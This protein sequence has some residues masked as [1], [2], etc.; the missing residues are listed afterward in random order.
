MPREH[1]I[2]NGVVVAIIVFFITAF[3]TTTLQDNA[4]VGYKIGAADWVFPDEQLKVDFYIKNSGNVNVIPQITIYVENATIEKVEIPDMAQYQLSNF[5]TYDDTCAN[6]DNLT[7]PAH[8]DN[9]GLWASV[10]IVPNE[11]AVSFTVN[12]TVNIPFDLF[13]LR[14]DVG[15]IPPSEFIY[16]F[17]A[18]GYSF[19]KL[20]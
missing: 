14:P 7:L 8:Y 5:C 13:H 20:K 6:F 17:P 2:R 4:I 19:E 11:G 15:R 1:A 9:L 16:E 10:Y 3:F 18:N 12:S